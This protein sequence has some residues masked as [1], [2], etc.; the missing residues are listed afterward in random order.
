MIEGDIRDLY[1]AMDSSNDPMAILARMAME[2][3]AQMARLNENLER[4][5]RAGTERVPFVV[6]IAKPQ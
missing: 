5:D 6:E 1:H 3:A 2:L 4:Q